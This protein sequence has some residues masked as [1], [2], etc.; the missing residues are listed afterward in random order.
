MLTFP[1][2]VP[3]LPKDGTTDT[4]MFSR[5]E[6]ELISFPSE[7]PPL[8]CPQYSDYKRLPEK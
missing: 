4:I 2:G 6:L 8:Q 5:G 1:S 3:P 7:L